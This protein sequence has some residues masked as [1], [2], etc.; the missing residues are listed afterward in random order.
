MGDYVFKIKQK[1]YFDKI[2]NKRMLP[3]RSY[4]QLPKY[5][6]DIS[7]SYQTMFI[8]DLIS[9]ITDKSIILDLGC[10]DGKYS[11]IIATKK[12]S[13]YVIG[14]DFSLPA[15]K[16]AQKRVA[17]DA[18]QRVDFILCDCEYLPFRPKTFDVAVIIDLL[19]HLN[20]LNVLW[21]I[22]GLMK[23]GGRCV[24]NDAVS[25]NP[26]FSLG[27]MIFTY[28]SRARLDKEIL[29][30]RQFTAGELLGCLKVLNFEVIKEKRESLFF[31]IL[32]YLL[33]Y[34]PWIRFLISDAV[35]SLLHQLEM[36]LIKNTPF[37][38]LCQVI[39]IFGRFEA[40]LEE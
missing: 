4:E 35:S 6:L 14:V 15:L 5:L 7:K 20:G 19:H 38:N 13:A 25:N 31:F 11:N 34:I 9:F 23:K 16:L 10:G 32:Y 8:K 24:I 12:E 28:I 39:I 26:L 17:S 30:T 21:E 3:K 36:F 18:R 40:S 29:P 33:R 1:R 2:F 37:K 22:R 27:K